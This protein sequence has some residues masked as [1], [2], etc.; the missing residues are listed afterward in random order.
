M[1]FQSALGTPYL[2]PCAKS[3]LW[4]FFLKALH[5]IFCDLYVCIVDLDEF[6]IIKFFFV[7]LG[8]WWRRW[9]WWWW[10][11]GRLWWWRGQGGWILKLAPWLSLPIYEF[12]SNQKKLLI[13]MPAS[14]EIITL[15]LSFCFLVT[16]PDFKK[17]QCNNTMFFFF[18]FFFLSYSVEKT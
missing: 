9:W 2:W 15:F 14:P 1:W 16:S 3:K 12:L 10:W 18:C 8:H 11:C 7:G 17:K 13:S 5:Y 4:F 6:S